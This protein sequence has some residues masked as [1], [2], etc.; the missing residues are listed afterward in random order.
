[1]RATSPRTRRRRSKGVWMKV[2]DPELLARYMENADFSQARL[3]RY[4]GVSRQF[5]HLL[6]TGE[7][8][9]CTKDVGE[10]IEEALRVLP[11]TLFVPQKSP[12]RGPRVSRKGTAA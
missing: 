11:G 5:I 3:A 1:M 8:R 6:V 4:T 9:T 7:R 2:R 12:S 10:L